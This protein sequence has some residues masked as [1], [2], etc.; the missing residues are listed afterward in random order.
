MLD[1]GAFTEL[2]KHS[3]SRRLQWPENSTVTINLSFNEGNHREFWAR[4]P[5]K[6]VNQDHLDLLKMDGLIG[7]TSQSRFRLVSA[8]Y[9]PRFALSL[10]LRLG[11]VTTVPEVSEKTYDSG[12]WENDIWQSWLVPTQVENGP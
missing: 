7:C 12:R 9:S 4:E 6:Q 5:S 11:K 1:V 3:I 2:K 8:K 10:L